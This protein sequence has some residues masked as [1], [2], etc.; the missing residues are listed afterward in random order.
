VILN[1]YA[2]GLQKLFAEMSSVVTDYRTG[3]TEAGDDI[4]F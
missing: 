4:L 3:G 1:I 2:L